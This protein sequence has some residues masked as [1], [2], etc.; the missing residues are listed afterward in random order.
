MNSSSNS[1]AFITTLIFVILLGIFGLSGVAIFYV[2]LLE[3]SAGFQLVL[4]FSGVIAWLLGAIFAVTT[5][6]YL[7][8]KKLATKLSN[9]ARKMTA[10]ESEAGQHLDNG[11]TSRLSSIQASDAVVVDEI[12]DLENAFSK[13]TA[14]IESRS[15][16]AK[17]V[18]LEHQEVVAGVAHDLRLPLMALH[19][20]LEVLNLSKNSFSDDERTILASAL[21][22]SNRLRALSQELFELAALEL[23]DQ[24]IECENFFL[25]ELIGDIVQEF[26]YANKDVAFTLSPT[27]DGPLKI[28][29]N[30]HLIDRAVTNLIDNAIK[31]GGVRQSPTIAIKI[32]ANGE[33]FAHVL[34]EDNGAGLSDEILGRLNVGSC[35]RVPPLKLNAESIGGLGLAISQRIAT[36]HGG[37]IDAINVPNGGARIRLTLNITEA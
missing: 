26:I 24:V 17:K 35:L 28:R 9:L 1:L 3:R 4:H 16:A 25:D 5:C 27:S 32:Q 20:K 14:R 34:I 8:S 22:Q 11:C 12:S 2:A 30:I 21:V 19:S 10:Y 29:G 23:T 7:A 37:T 15:R 31:H 13:L 18:S 33:R 36:L 6:G